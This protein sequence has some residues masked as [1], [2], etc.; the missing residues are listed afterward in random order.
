MDTLLLSTR[1]IKKLLEYWLALSRSNPKLT[2]R[3]TFHNFIK[4]KIKR[5]PPTVIPVSGREDQWKDSSKQPQALDN[6]VQNKGNCGVSGEAKLDL[7]IL[8]T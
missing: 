3:D 6:K 1:L 5:T 4:E 8:P 7:F 2:N